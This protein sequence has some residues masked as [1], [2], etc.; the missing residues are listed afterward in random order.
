MNLT[1]DITNKFIM[2]SKI[3]GRYIN[4]LIDTGADISMMHENFIPP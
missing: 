3:F 4:Y 2:S 1:Y